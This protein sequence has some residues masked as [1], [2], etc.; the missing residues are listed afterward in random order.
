MNRITKF[1]TVAAIGAAGV[2]GLASQAGAT[3]AVTDGVGHVDKGDVQKALGW[4]NGDFDTALAPGGVGVKFTAQTS[5]STTTRWSC[6]GGEQ[7][8][9]STVI[10][11]TPVTATV[12]KSANGRQITGW[13]LT[14]VGVGGA[15]VSGGYTGAPYNAYCPAAE[16][17]GGFLPHVFANGVII[18]GTFAV[19]GIS[20]P[21][22]PV[23]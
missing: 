10:Q 22:T 23:V 9:T 15:F 14:G 12:V 19:N 3:V 6:S 1:L 20:L 11:A 5:N 13:D 16:S 21:N 4:N 18:P 17:F 2:V 7:S 8:R